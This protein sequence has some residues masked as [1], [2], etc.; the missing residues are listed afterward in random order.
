V[1]AA[2]ARFGGHASGRHDFGKH[3]KEAVLIFGKP[4]VLRRVL[5]VTLSATLSSQGYVF[6]VVCR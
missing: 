2:A 5:G 3:D 1:I 4:S 6:E